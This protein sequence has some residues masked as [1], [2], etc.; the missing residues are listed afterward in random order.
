MSRYVWW[1]SISRHV[2]KPAVIRMR[3]CI[4]YTTSCSTNYCFRLKKRGYATFL[5]ELSITLGSVASKTRLNGLKKYKQ[6]K[7]F[8]LISYYYEFFQWNFSFIYM[9]EERDRKG[10][11][12]RKW[13]SSKMGHRPDSNMGCCGMDTGS[14]YGVRFI[15]LATG[16]FRLIMGVGQT[17]LY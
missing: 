7:V 16:V 17:T 4:Q 10:G 5:S 8:F 15:R 2:F 13:H 14:V 6:A 12:E 1:V 3:V 11:R 9:T